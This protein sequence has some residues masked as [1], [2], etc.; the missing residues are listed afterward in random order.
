LENLVNPERAGEFLAI[1]ERVSNRYCWAGWQGSNAE[2]CIKLAQGP[3][4]VACPLVLK[5]SF[6]RSPK[7]PRRFLLKD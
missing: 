2:M 7:N 3:D 1:S 5:I 4:C 6:G